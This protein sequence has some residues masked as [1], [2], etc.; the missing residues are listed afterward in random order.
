M[1]LMSKISVILLAAFSMLFISCVSLPGGKNHGDT[2]MSYKYHTVLIDEKLD[3]LETKIKYPQF[4]NIPELNK[5][6][7]NTEKADTN[8]ELTNNTL[9]S[10]NNTIDS[11]EKRLDEVKSI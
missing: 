2:K 10:E 9:E 5:K 6:I 3:Y 7:E 11:K 4:D 1:K 8:I